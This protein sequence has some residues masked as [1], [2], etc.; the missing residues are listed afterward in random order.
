MQNFDS[1]FEKWSEKHGIV[2]RGQGKDSF[3]DLSLNMDSLS[4]NNFKELLINF[5]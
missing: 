5:L 4:T 3:V 2:A 1:N